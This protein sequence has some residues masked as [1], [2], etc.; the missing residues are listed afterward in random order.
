[1]T[2]A[3]IRALA[4]FACKGCVQTSLTTVL[5]S[6]G[7]KTQ[8]YYLGLDYWKVLPFQ[9]PIDNTKYF[10]FY[11][12]NHKR[13]AASVLSEDVLVFVWGCH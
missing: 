10:F 5:F 12:T 13:G 1:M 2:H 6:H 4:T 11:V 7:Q 9:N 3:E 8:S